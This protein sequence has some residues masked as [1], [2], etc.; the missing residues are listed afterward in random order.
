MRLNKYIAQSGLASRRAADE[1]IAAG[2]VQVNGVV[3]RDMGVQINPIKDK[4][5]VEGKKIKI[6]VLKTYIM[7][8][9]PR[10]IL[11]SM[12]L[13]EDTLYGYLKEMAGLGLFHVGRL[14]RDSEGLLLLTNDGDW[15][16]RVSHPRYQVSKEYEI[17]T[18]Q[19]IKG[20]DLQQL[21][22]QVQLDDGPF[23]ADQA[24]RIGDRKVRIVIHDGRNR[25]LR[26]A[27]AAL[28]YEVVELK[29][30]AVGNLRLGKLR[31]GEWK[32]IDV[33]SFSS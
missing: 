28:N 10:G 15:G 33:S 5:K 22:E 18:D 30:T 32:E 20:S 4:V 2:K 1:L 23:K 9:K 19:Q 31:P 13:G 17:T 3:I 26:R 24:I 29:R 27:F 11:S 14:D 12:S 16:N 7:F 25:V 8:Y 6:D 21:M